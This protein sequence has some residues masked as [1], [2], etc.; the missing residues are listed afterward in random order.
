MSATDIRSVDRGPR[1]LNA[2][3]AERRQARADVRNDV[4]AGPAIPS[5]DPR[6][7]EM[8]SV[9]P[10]AA[11]VY[12][13]P[14][15]AMRVST[16]YAC[17][18]LL[19]GA[20][21]NM[22]AHVYR[23]GQDGRRERI[24]NDPLW[25]L[26]NEQPT[27]R[28]TAASWWEMVVNHQKLRGDHFAY[29]DR[30]KVG[31]PKEFIPLPWEEVT[32]FRQEAYPDRLAYT[33]RDG[34]KRI[35]VDQDDM[36]HFAGF[37]F[38]GLRSLSVISWAARNAAGNALAMDEYSGK[39][40]ANGAHA[41]M[42]LQ[43]DKG[44]KDTAIESLQRQFGEKYSGLPNAHKLPLVLTDG[45]KAEA[46]SLSAEDS[47]LIE[48]RRFQVVDIARAF[49][50]PPHLVGETT[51]TPALGTGVE[52]MN[53]QL[54]ATVNRDLVRIEQELNRKLFRTS[55]RF[56]EFNRD[57]LLAGDT[58]T[59]ADVWRKA[60]GGPGTG[61]G[62]MAVDEIRTLMNLPPA[63]GKFGEIYDPEP[64]ASGAGGSDT[65]PNEDDPKGT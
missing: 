24:Q 3:L 62:W 34:G 28:Y 45:L 19:A 39:F 47:Q 42:V 57:A 44:M 5:S 18:A 27:A 54:L 43:T 50:V 55:G 32:P 25:W 60:L 23:R 1:I 56:I 4:T 33:F 49:G 64:G 37:G 2:W 30:N 51:G 31:E 52:V 41:S 17:C 15:N 22:P 8:F 12:V 61:R 9:Q 59:Q 11:G 48:A 6:V 26:L 21:T 16:V 46:L 20:V 58:K 63:G 36:L 38:D 10:A 14:A 7:L 29:I 53:R 65:D 13:T 35:T 40:F